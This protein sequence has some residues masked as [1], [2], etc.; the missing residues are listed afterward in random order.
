MANNW[1]SK[2]EL[3]LAK[4]VDWVRKVEENS[5]IAKTLEKTK[6]LKTQK[7]WIR[8]ESKKN[9]TKLWTEVAASEVKKEAKLKQQNDRIEFIE[10]R[11]KMF[12]LT[13]CKDEYKRLFNWLDPKQQSDIVKYFYE[14][15]EDKENNLADVASWERFPTSQE[16]QTMKFLKWYLYLYYAWIN[17]KL[18][19]IK[20]NQL[21]FVWTDS[22]IADIWR[23]IESRFTGR[24][25]IF[26]FEWEKIDAA[27]KSKLEELKS[28]TKDIKYK[29]DV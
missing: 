18:A 19:F 9:R 21:P 16:L 1:L 17:E 26:S 20:L 27:F 11:D 3:M 7:A 23:M 10:K 25:R 4:L 29:E 12:S 5:E 2:D 28:N 15:L 6:D 22:K 24:G 13:E 14:A 8:A